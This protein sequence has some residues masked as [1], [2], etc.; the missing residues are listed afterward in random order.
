[1]LVS[2]RMVDDLR[3]IFFK[4]SIDSMGISHRTDQHYQVQ[5]RIIP[6]QFLLNVIGIVF[7]NIKDDQLLRLMS[8]DLTAKLASDGTASSCDQHD[9]SRHIPHDTLHLSINGFSSQQILNLHIAELGDTDLSVYQLIDS[10]QYLQ[11]AACLTADIQQFLN[12][13]MRCR[14]NGDH[15]LIN[16][17][18][19]CQT[20]D[21]LSVTC[22]QHT[23]QIL[24]DLARIIIHQAT[25]ILLYELAVLQFLQQGIASLTGSHDHGVGL[26]FLDQ[27][28][29][30]LTEVSK[31]PISKSEYRDSC[32]QHN[33]VHKRITSR[34]AKPHQ[35]HTDRLG[36]CGHQARHN[37][38]YQIRCTG[39]FPDSLIQP[40]SGKHDHC[41]DQIHRQIL[42]NIL[43]KLNGL[44]FKEQIIPHI[45]S[46]RTCCRD[47]QHVH[48][49]QQYDPKYH[50]FILV[51]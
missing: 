39:I 49:H 36:H 43:N 19:L 14:R 24:S 10:W 5:F 12:L 8:C 34:K 27:S 22:Y 25:H 9:F 4:H 2:C 44:R 40:K 37:N 45:D 51:F 35:S 15:N 13:S 16:M 21:I 26:A 6:L 50:F 23:A 3:M 48:Q 33:K 18:F 7:I 31:Y 1:M 17:I 28:L 46:Q 38:I 41:K 47:D 30:L 11:L 42:E 32:C 29:L 20:T